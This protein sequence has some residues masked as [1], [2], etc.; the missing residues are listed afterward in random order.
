M[1]TRVVI[2]NEAIHPDYPDQ[3]WQLCLQWVRYMGDDGDTHDGYRFIW[4]RPDASLQAARG[5]A[6][7]PSLAAAETL[8]QI[9]RDSGWGDH[10][11]D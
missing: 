11:G 4:R 9:A 10:V 7:I 8:F 3:D 6:R 5:Q 1:P 2:F